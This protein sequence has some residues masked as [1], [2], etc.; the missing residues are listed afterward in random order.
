MK[1]YTTGVNEFG[2]PLFP[3]VGQFISNVLVMEARDAQPFP[4]MVLSRVVRSGCFTRPGSQE[5]AKGGRATLKY[6][7]SNLMEDGEGHTAYFV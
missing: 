4:F 7:Y 2:P 6:A 3:P 5:L 1:V